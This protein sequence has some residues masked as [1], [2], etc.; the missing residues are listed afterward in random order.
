MDKTERK[1]ETSNRHNQKQKV[2]KQNKSQ[3]ERNRE[4]K[5]KRLG[6]PFTYLSNI[7]SHLPH[8]DTT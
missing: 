7:K 8:T 6:Q 5:R 1:K 3:R 4:R 2:R